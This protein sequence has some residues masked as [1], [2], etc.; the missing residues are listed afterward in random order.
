MKPKDFSLQAPRLIPEQYFAQPLEGS[1]MFF[2][3]FKNAK[4]FFTIALN[5]S[6]DGERLRLVEKLTYSTGEVVDRTYLIVKKDEHHYEAS[7]AD[8][9]GVANIESYGNVMRWRYRLRQP[10][11]DSVWTLSFDD[12]MFLQPDQT[13]INRAT[14]SKFGIEVGEVFMSLKAKQ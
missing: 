8:V 4:V 9:V 10:I 2:D 11:G 1:G 7:T 13:I 5:G 6:W 12:W 3:R 14:A